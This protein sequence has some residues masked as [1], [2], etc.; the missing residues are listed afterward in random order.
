M[1]LNKLLATLLF[2]SLFGAC[3]SS[4]DG[5]FAGCTTEDAGIIAELNVAGL[6]Q[7]GPFVKGSAVTV[8]GIDCKTLK[9]T[10][11]LFEGSVKNDKGEFVVDS[12]TL[13]STCAVF[14]V[15]GY[16]LN[17]LTGKK[18]TEKLTLHALTD[19][20]DRKNVNINVLTELEYLR[21]IHLVTVEKMSFDDAKKQAE[22]EVLAS[23]N[24]K[25]NIAKSEDLNIL[26][27][28]DGNA[29]LLAV[30]IMA[31]ADAKESQI[32]ERLDE[33]AAAISQNGSLD[34]DTKKEIAEW[35]TSA[36][37]SGKLDTIR[38][39]IE[40]WGYADSVPAFETYVKAV[41]NGDSVTLNGK[42]D[43]GTKAGMTSSSKDV[44][45][46][47]TSSSSGALSS[48]KEIASS[49]SSSS[50]VSL[51]GVEVSSSSA[52]KEGDGSEYDATANTLK[53]LRDGKT[54]RTT[55]IGGQVWMAENLN[56]ETPNSYCYNDSAEYCEKYGRLYTIAA[57]VDS[58]GTFSSTGVGCGLGVKCSLEGTVR[59]A[60]PSGWHL[61]DAD[62]WK[63]LFITAGADVKSENPLR[64]DMNV[65]QTFKVADKLMSK[66]GWGHV[67]Y[68]MGDRKN[69][70]TDDF[71]FSVLPAGY[72]VGALAMVL[73]G[74]T[75]HYMEPGNTAGFLYVYE[76]P[77]DSTFYGWTYNYASIIAF[78]S[79]NAED[80]DVKIDDNN[81]DNAYS[82]RCIK[83]GSFFMPVSS[84][85]AE[86]SSSF[87][88]VV[89]SSSKDK[90]SSSVELASPC[91]TRDSDNC[92]YGTLTDDRDG[93]TYKTVKI[94]KQWWMAEN[95]NY[96]YTDVPYKYKEDEKVYT[97]DSTSW[98]YG[99]NSS[100]CAE[101]GR[102][103]TWAAAMDSAG[104]WSTNGK[105]CGYSKTCSPTYPI[106]G[107]CPTG[108]HLPDITEW[109]TLFAAVGGESTAGQM[110]LK[111]TTGWSTNGVT[112]SN[113]YAFSA[114]LAGIRSYNGEYIFEGEDAYF[115]SSTEYDRNGVYYVGFAYGVDSAA[116]SYSVKYDGFP[117]RCL[118]D[119]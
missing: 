20:K 64:P 74:G 46:T 61:P 26:E 94:G 59:G 80:Y 49:S 51:S 56:Y 65:H 102:F 60:C 52:A 5:G 93:Q 45:S 104:T 43:S 3:T 66:S 113:A 82:V 10:N 42:G 28:G 44:E 76:R 79:F 95:L 85:S 50:S 63:A 67:S 89:S 100:N 14:E 13:S 87:A 30:S 70:G 96:A 91:R 71:G 12:V 40:S 108:W 15:S 106:R 99:D 84:S 4:N 54:Y 47:E 58:I 21:V 101:Y 98:C 114:L 19:L 37:A 118:K 55:K 9:F 6:T 41:A 2:L 92:E 39:N 35:A 53:D 23:F 27:A 117:V 7:K 116:K 62:E 16:Y 109:K 78:I 115:W 17:E 38:K 29:A 110:L 32:A 33:Y 73:D 25:G 11:E 69:I 103:Y 22:K 31:L 1:N 72:R 24:I 48:G 105:G 88:K 68:I 18:S 77:G 112:V 111:W 119:E 97:S 86:S 75:P 8:Q 34:G 90:S 81:K 83:D 57:A 107:V 36:V